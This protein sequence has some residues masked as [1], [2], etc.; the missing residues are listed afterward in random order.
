MDHLITSTVWLYSTLVWQWCHNVILLRLF[1]ILADLS[2]YETKREYKWVN[3]KQSHVSYT[4]MGALECWRT[5]TQR[6]SIIF[7]LLLTLFCCPLQGCPG[8]LI[9]VILGQ[10]YVPVGAPPP[11][12]SLDCYVILRQILNYS[13]F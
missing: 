7:F 10:M 13:F 4:Y 11:F 5:I 12:A 1:M 3:K 6:F 9:S 2:K 8:I